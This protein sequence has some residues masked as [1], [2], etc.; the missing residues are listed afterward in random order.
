MPMPFYL[1]MAFFS[2]AIALAYPL[3][4]IFVLMSRG[5]RRYYGPVTE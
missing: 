3:G 5:V 2:A 4:L 1:V